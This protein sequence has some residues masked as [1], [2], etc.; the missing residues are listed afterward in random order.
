MNKL[1]PL[2]Y[3]PH[4]GKIRIAFATSG[5]LILDITVDEESLG[6]IDSTFKE[7]SEPQKRLYKAALKVIQEVI[8]KGDDK[9]VDTVGL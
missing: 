9:C 3:F 8:A 7:G 5:N 4:A 1:T 2:D 6:Y